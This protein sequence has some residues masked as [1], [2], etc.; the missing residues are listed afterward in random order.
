MLANAAL[1][2][3]RAAPLVR[4]GRVGPQQR[5]RFV[6]GLAGWTAGFC[7]AVQLV[8][9]FTG[10]SRP[11][12]LA[13]FPPDTPA[14]LATTALTAVGW[15]ALLGWVWRGRGAETLA[16][17]GPAFTPG[18]PAGRGYDPAKV[19]RFVTAL[20]VLSVLGGIVASR[21]APPPPDCRGATAT[22][23]PGVPAP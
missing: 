16:A 3:V 10:E 15:A 6:L 9:W 12:C 23:D 22:S 7:V 20:V 4:N 11:E 2:H 13:A 5:R 1:V 8:V 14:S 21:I 17:F 19:R 18:R